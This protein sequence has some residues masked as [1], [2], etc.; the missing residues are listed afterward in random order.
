MCYFLN[1]NTIYSFHKFLFHFIHFYRTVLLF[2]CGFSQQ[3]N[4]ANTYNTHTY[5]NMNIYGEK[6]I[7]IKYCLLQKIIIMIKLYIINVQ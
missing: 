7:S 6:L 2:K 1:I 4:A 3:I 5:I